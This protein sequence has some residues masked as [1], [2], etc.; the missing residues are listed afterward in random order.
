MRHAIVS[1]PARNAGMNDRKT[2]TWLLVLL[3]IVAL[4]VLGPPLLALTMVSVGLVLSLAT[5][6][7]KLGVLAAIVYVVYRLVRSAFGASAT[8][9][10]SADLPSAI[11]MPDDLDAVDSA[12]EREDRAQRQALDRE[13]ERAQAARPSPQAS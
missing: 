5:A 11:A 1:L 2:P 9:D 8:P 3:G 7:I 6:G 13:L 4:F 12:L 10:R